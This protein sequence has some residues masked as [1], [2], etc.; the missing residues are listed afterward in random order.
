MLQ[1][2]PGSTTEV[3]PGHSR[4]PGGVKAL[5]QAGLARIQAPQL[6]EACFPLSEVS[7]LTGQIAQITEQ[8]YG[9]IVPGRLCRA[10]Q[11][12]D[13]VPKLRLDRKSVV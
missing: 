9:F 10:E 13:L 7:T 5:H 12:T 6:P 11:G 3:E 8:L 4:E 2:R 1:L